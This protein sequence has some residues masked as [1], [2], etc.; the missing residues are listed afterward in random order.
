MQNYPLRGIKG[1]MGTSQDMLDLLGTSENVHALEEEVR[2]SLGFEVSLSSVGQ[3]YPR[4]LDFDVLS[5]LVQI[6]AVASTFATTLR[7]MAGAELAA[8]G[9]KEDQTGSSAMPHKMNER[10]YLWFL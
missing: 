8:E 6:G 2:K 7:L 9:F 4:T 5:N 3:V 1:P 10:T